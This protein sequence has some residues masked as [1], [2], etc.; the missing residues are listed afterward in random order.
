[1]IGTALSVKGG[2]TSVAQNYLEHWKYS[3]HE[4]KYAPTYIEGRK[5][6]QILYFI[7]QY[8]NI[9]FLLMSRKYSIVHIHMTH[10]GSTVRKGIIAYT[11]SILKVKYIVH[12]HLEYRPFYESLSNISKKFVS[13]IFKKSSC[14]IVLS[15]DM[16]NC[17]R[18]INPDGRIEIIN[19]GVSIPDRNPYNPCANN[20]LF[21]G[22]L[23]KRKGI[24]DIFKCIRLLDN[25]LPKNVKLLLCGEGN[26]D[27]IKDDIEKYNISHRIGHLGWITNSEKSEIFR[28]SAIC[29]LPSYQEGLPMSILETMANG[30][31]NISTF[32]SGIPSIIKN[33]FN[34]LLI[35][36][37][38]IEDLRKKIILILTDDNL[39]R[40]L[41]DNAYSTIKAKFSL[42]EMMLHTYDVYDEIL[43]SY[44]NE[45]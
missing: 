11:A 22:M 12:L 20:I 29:I 6:I 27:F 14:S 40:K 33:G 41:S 7:F 13:G 24:H 19:N 28:Q 31:P 5:L 23:S 44:L 36:P 26:M 39:R 38:D 30:I 8:F 32:I 2:M 25:D 3:S 21:L 45:K 9:L 4:I 43:S 15:A 17:I 10:K 42:K 34:G 16:L 18:E 35:N 1:M 37:G